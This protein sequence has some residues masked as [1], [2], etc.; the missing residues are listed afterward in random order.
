M[1]VALCVCTFVLL[2][3]VVSADCQFPPTCPD[4]CSFNGIYFNSTGECRCDR[5]YTNPQCNYEQKSQLTAFLTQLFVG[6]LGVA[7]FIVGRIGIGVGKLILSMFGSCGIAILICVLSVCFDKRFAAKLGS[8]IAILV[9]LG[10]F[11]WWLTDTILFGMNKIPDGNGVV[12][13][14]M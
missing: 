1:K 6:Y 4:Y 13:Y 9:A 2:I 5:G 11:V 10:V 14:P 7:D 12:L 8:L 3:V